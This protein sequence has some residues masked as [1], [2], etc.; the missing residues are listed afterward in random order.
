MGLKITVII[1]AVVGFAY[2]LFLSVIERHS[3]SN[4][5][6]DNLKDVYD[7]ETYERWKKYTAEHVKLD[8]VFKEIS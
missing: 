3:I 4:P 6:P 8:I 1:V 7:N 2:S 5:T